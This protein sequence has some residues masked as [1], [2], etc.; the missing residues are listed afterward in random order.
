MSERERGIISVLILHRIWSVDCCQQ[1]TAQLRQYLFSVDDLVHLSSS[2]VNIDR[3]A[4]RQTTVHNSNLVSCR[5]T[6]RL[7]VLYDFYR[8]GK[9]LKYMKKQREAEKCLPPSK[10]L[11]R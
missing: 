3:Q 9:K 8:S 10:S 7:S 4:G 5:Q 11:V 6:D 2:E 1:F